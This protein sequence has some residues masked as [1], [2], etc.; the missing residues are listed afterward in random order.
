[1]GESAYLDL[2]RNIR[3]DL[4]D[5]FGSNYVIEHVAAEYNRRMEERLFREYVSEVLKCTAEGWGARISCSYSEMINPQK[6]EEPENGDEIALDVIRRAG[7]KG[8]TDGL[9]ETEGD[10]VAG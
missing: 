3:L 2:C 7:L 9:H 4:L 8:T 6:K 5:M 10:S 1:M